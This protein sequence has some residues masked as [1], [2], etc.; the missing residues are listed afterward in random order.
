M[1]DDKIRWNEKYRTCPIPSQVA[2]VVR[3]FAPSAPRG[4]GL[5]I[6]CGTGRH[7]RYMAELGFEV[8]A[9][10][11]SDYALQRMGDDPRIRKIEADLEQYRI[12][13]GCYDLIVNC[14]YLDRRLYGMIAE[15]LRPG[16]MLI[17]E[18]FLEADGAEYHQ[19]S[20]PDFVLK[21]GE[22][23]SAFGALEL[24]RYDEREDVNL[25]GEKVRV[26]TFVG[27]KERV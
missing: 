18:T 11:L 7:S 8:D 19:P 12:A 25:R 27:R 14:N 6:A 10:D 21:P 2:A 23:R 13:P 26:A 4:R 16:G 9:V 1:L 15:A 20:N 24:L 22:L 5:D 3:E 17:F